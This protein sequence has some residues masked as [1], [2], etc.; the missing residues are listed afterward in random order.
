MDAIV[1]RDVDLGRL[2]GPDAS[3]DDEGT[4]IVQ[5]SSWMMILGTVRLL[6][7]GGDYASAFLTAN[8]AAWPTYSVLTR[9]LQENSLPILLAMSWPLLI[10]LALRRSRSNSYLGAAALT[11]FILGLGGILLLVEGLSLRY[12]TTLVVGS[13]TV[14]RSA[15]AHHRAADLV[16]SV[17]GGNPVGSRTGDSGLRVQ[18][19][20]ATSRPTD[21]RSPFPGRLAPA[22]PRPPCR[23]SQPGLSRPEHEDALLDG[24]PRGS[25]PVQPGP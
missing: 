12:D 19:D 20:H 25:E 21:R 3:W 9:F 15:L 1:P 13:F 18:P 8:G 23:L 10:G 7:A 17:D 16:R 11:F 22:A 14:S 4:R 2:A 24:L 5:I 6:C